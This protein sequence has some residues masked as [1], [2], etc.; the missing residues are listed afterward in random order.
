MRQSCRGSMDVKCDS[1]N[2][3]SMKTHKTNLTRMFSAILAHNDRDGRVVKRRQR[4]TA[5]AWKRR[6]QHEASLL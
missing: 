4:E 1:K 2:D 3:T 5:R 6:L